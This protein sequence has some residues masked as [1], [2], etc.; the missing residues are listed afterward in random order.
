MHNSK[1]PRRRANDLY[2]DTW[3]PE[4]TQAMRQEVR[5]FAEKELAPIAHQLNTPPENKDNFPWELMK[6]MGDAGILRIPY[7]KEMGGRGLKYPLLASQ[8]A[9]E[10][11][12][13]FSNGAAAALYDAPMAL[14]GASLLRFAPDEIAQTYLPQLMSGEI[15]GSFATSEPAASTD[16]SPDVLSTIAEA[17]PGGFRVNGAKR[18]ITNACVASVLVFL[19]KTEEGLTMLFTRMDEEGITVSDPD[20]KM[21]NLA[22]LT[23]DITFDNVFVPEAN[24]IGQK[25]RGLRV[26]LSA[27]TEG[28]VAVASMGV[29][30]GQAAFDHATEFMEQRKVFGKTLSSMQHW[31]NIFANYAIELENARNLCYKAAYVIDTTGGTESPLGPMAKTYATK[32]SSKIASDAM[33]VCGAMGFVRELGATGE[34]RPIEAIYRDTKIGEI[35]EGANEVM[36]TVIARSIFGKNVAV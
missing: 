5:A 36:L 31:Q 3:L 22:Q 16:L 32:L 13:Y 21:G 28:R 20:K 4:E 18:W 30:L 11:L 29:G 19:C 12:A 24:V 25:G 10:E 2:V 8:V 17:V 23:S 15:T 33:Q 9:E 6:K 7:A 26:A 35:Y 34:L 14:L 27:L 1:L